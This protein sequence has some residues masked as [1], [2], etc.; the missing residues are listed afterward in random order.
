M[1]SVFG[2][3]LGEGRERFANACENRRLR[4]IRMRSRAWRIAGITVAMAIGAKTVPTFTTAPASGA[5]AIPPKAKIRDEP[6]AEGEDRERD[7]H[8]VCKRGPAK[9]LF[10]FAENAEC[11]T[12]IGSQGEEG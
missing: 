11:G 1:L 2:D 8:D 12:V 6:Q 3:T 7:V 5:A 4:I 10:G 9:G